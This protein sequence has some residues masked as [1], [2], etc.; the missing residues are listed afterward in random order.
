MARIKKTLKPG[1]L[2]RGAE[3]T[4]EVEAVLGT[5]HSGITYKAKTRVTIANVT[6]TVYYAI[7]EFFLAEACAR[8]ED[9]SITVNIAQKELFT[10]QLNAFRHEAELLRDM[11]NHKGIVSVTEVI[12]AFNTSYYVMEYLGDSL[13]HYMDSVPCRILA[14]PKALQIFLEISE[15]VSFLHSHHRLHLDIKP[16]N[17]MFHEGHPKLIDFGQSRTF[18]DNDAGIDNESVSPGYS[19]LEQYSGITHFAPSADIYALGATFLFMLTGKTPVEAKEM[20]GEY[21]D[22]VLPS[23]TSEETRQVLHKCLARG[24][25]QRGDKITDILS[26]LGYI[27]SGGNDTI[28]IGVKQ[29]SQVRTKHW[30]GIARKALMTVLAIV[31]LSVAAWIV[32]IFLSH[33]RHKPDKDAKADSTYIVQ[34]SGPDSVTTTVEAETETPKETATKEQPQ[35]NEPKEMNTTDGKPAK[36]SEPET[37]KVSALGYASWD[38]RIRDGEPDGYGTMT[39]IYAH[40]IP[41]TSINANAGDVLKGTFSNGRLV[42]GE[43]NGKYIEIE[44]Q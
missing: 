10:A 5:G 28:P 42:N 1:T 38:G 32:S 30:Q 7:K 36:K 14:E 19:P 25:R 24:P 34:T 12:D 20:T 13:T 22:S 29:S 9:G 37:P 11:P 3:F 43:I 33:N 21:I 27:I 4:Y 23:D 26:I 18:D 6:H 17:I 2:L 15:A 44:E 41:G 40:K 31:A 8:E 16:D 35:E 39:F